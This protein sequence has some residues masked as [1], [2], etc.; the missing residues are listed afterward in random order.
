VEVWY[1]LYAIVK[2]VS[3]FEQSDIASDNLKAER[4][5]LNGKGHLKAT[6]EFA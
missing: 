1:I 2:A 4:I 5:L 3:M 6:H